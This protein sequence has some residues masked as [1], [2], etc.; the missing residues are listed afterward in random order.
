MIA[1]ASNATSR[2][3]STP[4]IQIECC[5]TQIYLIW[6]KV[7]YAMEKAHSQGARDRPGK[8]E[9]SENLISSG[10]IT[11]LSIV[12]SCIVADW[13]YSGRQSKTIS[14]IEPRHEGRN[15]PH[16]SSNNATLHMLYLTSNLC[17]I[18]SDCHT[19]C[20]S[21]ATKHLYLY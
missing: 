21:D 19:I 4:H 15:S 9:E 18:D 17:K 1:Q 20:Q 12:H 5:V 14:D 11:S 6:A 8:D 2:F 3:W 10:Q 7:N 13:Q 16:S